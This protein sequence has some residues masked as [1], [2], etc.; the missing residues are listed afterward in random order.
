M[1]KGGISLSLRKIIATCGL[2]VLLLVNVTTCTAAFNAP[3]VGDMTVFTCPDG[4]EFVSIC[5]EMNGF[6]AISD[7][8]NIY[9]WGVDYNNVPGNLPPIVDLALANQHAVALDA[10]GNI[11]YWGRPDFNQLDFP[12][13]LPKIVE[14]EAAGYRTLLLTEDGGVLSVGD[15]NMGNQMYVPD[16]PAVEKITC[17]GYISAAL[18]INGTVHVWERSNLFSPVPQGKALDIAAAAFDIVALDENG[19]IVG[20]ITSGLDMP[21]KAYKGA[22]SGSGFVKLAGGGSGSLAAID[23]EGN[24]TIWGY[25]S[26]VEGAIVDVPYGLP[27]VKDAAVCIDSVACLG[28]DGKIYAW[29]PMVDRHAFYTY[30][31][32]GEQSQQTTTDKIEIPDVCWNTLTYANQAIAGLPVII[33]DVKIVYRPNMV[34]GMIVGQWPLP[35]QMDAPEEGEYITMTLLLTTNIP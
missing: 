28:E 35:G 25:Y 6:G 2:F 16:M 21:D 32:S 8:G 20:D 10:D 34:P 26:D 18:D 12:E 9:L 29:G 19:Q 11:Y 23:N 1:Q 30:A 24:I 31:P 33:T 5:G 27:P 14:I 7:K 3:L 17:S 4:G 13:D 15:P 22:P